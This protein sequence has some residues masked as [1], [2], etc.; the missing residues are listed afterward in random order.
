LRCVRNRALLDPSRRFTRPALTR[1]HGTRDLE[2]FAILRKRYGDRLAEV[3]PTRAS[4][5]YLY[6]DRLG[7]PRRVERLNAKLTRR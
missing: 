1:P 6:G 2:V 7:A 3:Q 4:E 5:T